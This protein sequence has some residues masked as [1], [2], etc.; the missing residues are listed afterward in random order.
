MVQ[1]RAV[2]HRSRTRALT[3]VRLTTLVF[4]P[5]YLLISSIRK[6]II[7]GEQGWISSSLLSR[8]MVATSA[9]ISAG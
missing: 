8:Y 2:K 3:A 6:E 1:A 7:V 9:R 5:V 4:V